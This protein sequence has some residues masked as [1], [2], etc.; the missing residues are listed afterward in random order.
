MRNI[1]AALLLSCALNVAHA[2]SIYDD[3]QGVDDELPK[4]DDNLDKIDN[5][6]NK[7]DSVPEI[8]DELPEIKD[9]A[10]LRDIDK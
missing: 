3:E 7:D 5:A 6:L 4:I 2:I 9:G 8:K 1:L 10:E